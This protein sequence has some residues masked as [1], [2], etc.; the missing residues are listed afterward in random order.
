M[1]NLEIIY[2]LFFRPTIGIRA[3]REKRPLGLVFFI[4]LFSLLAGAVANTV[5][6]TTD[7][8]IAIFSLSFNLI[9]RFL[10][11]LLSLFLLACMLHFIAEG[12][13]GEGKVGILFILLCCSLLPGIL[14]SPMSLIAACI[15]S[16]P[17]KVIFYSLF[18]MAILL[19]TLLLQILALKEAY[20][21][22]SGR[23]I[24]AYIILYSG[25]SLFLFILLC[26]SLALILSLIILAL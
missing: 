26:L 19:W 14:A 20:R 10:F 11:I 13:K 25:A 17:L 9:L 8:M 1:W 5:V 7:P 15:K 24:L 4:F 23:A 12:L 18:N 22:S 2:S 3:V 6:F 16:L 21:I